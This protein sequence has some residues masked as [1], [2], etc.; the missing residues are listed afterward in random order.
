MASA[1]TKKYSAGEAAV[2][3]INAGADIVLQP[4]DLEE[5]VDAVCEAVESGEIMEERIDESVTR[6]LAEKAEMGLI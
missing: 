6:I 4:A 2:M 5:A 1:I 3:A